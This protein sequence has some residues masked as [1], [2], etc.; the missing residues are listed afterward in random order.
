MVCECVDNKENGKGEASSRHG[1]CH[2]IVV[3]CGGGTLLECIMTIS[4]IHILRTL[5]DS[6]WKYGHGEFRMGNFNVNVPMA[7]MI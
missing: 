4:Y 5:H 1:A 3:Y 6:V 2:R 7:K